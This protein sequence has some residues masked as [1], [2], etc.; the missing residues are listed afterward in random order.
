MTAA[1]VAVVLARGMGR[2]MRE[3]DEAAPLDEAQQHAA[4]AGHKAMMPVGAAGRPF[5]DYVLSALA[6]AGCTEAVLVVAPDADAVRARYATVPGARLRVTWAVQEE[7][8]G[9]AHALLAAAPSVGDRPF[10][11]VN[12][13]NLYPETVLHALVDAEGPAL[14]GF[15]RSALVRESGFPAERVAQFAVL[16]VDAHGWLTGIHEKPDPARLAAAGADGL[17]SMNVWRFD[18]RIFDACRRVPRSVRG[19][20]ELPEAVALAVAGGLRVRVLP[21][22]GAVI[23]LSRRAD[24]AR[25]RA[26]LAA[27]EPR[28]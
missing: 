19:E 7:A 23:D 20:Y 11:V 15:V 1:R 18:A 27:V 13:D 24:V 16:D 12:A 9:T 21:A 3:S 4:A 6:D 8:T 17:I 5:L 26:R 14:P 2:R 25:V 10:L 28:W 22:A